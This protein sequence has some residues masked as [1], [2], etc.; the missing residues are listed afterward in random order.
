MH[1]A[2]CDA[3]AGS[4][5]DYSAGCVSHQRGAGYGGRSETACGLRLEAETL[6]KAVKYFLDEEIVVVE[7]KVVFKP[8]I[9]AFAKAGN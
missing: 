1:S 9:S 2:Y 3:G 5:A 6:T 7:R 8:G 4:G